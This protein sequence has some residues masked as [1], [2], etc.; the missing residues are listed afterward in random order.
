MGA[1]C[2]KQ[3]SGSV[4]VIDLRDGQRYVD[5]NRTGSGIEANDGKRGKRNRKGAPHRDPTN[6]FKH[7]GKQKLPSK[8]LRIAK[9]LDPL[10]EL[11]KEQ[12]TEDKS[13]LSLTTSAQ[14]YTQ[15]KY[16]AVGDT[17]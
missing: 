1:K 15:T 3:E 10:S 13:A 6:V 12:D 9:A 2:F 7:G 4:E 14:L 8:I 16:L 17:Q 5:Q 11:K